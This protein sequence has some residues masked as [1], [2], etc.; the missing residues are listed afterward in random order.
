MEPTLLIGVMLYST[1]ALNSIKENLSIDNVVNIVTKAT[2]PGLPKILSDIDIETA[3]QVDLEFQFKNCDNSVCQT[4]V[5]QSQKANVSKLANM[6]NLVAVKLEELAQTRFAEAEK[7]FEKI[8]DVDPDEDFETA[9]EAMFLQLNSLMDQQDLDDIESMPT[10]VL[11][12]IDAL[13]VEWLGS[14]KRR[15][16]MEQWLTQ[17]TTTIAQLEHQGQKFSAAAAEYQLG[18]IRLEKQKDW[19]RFVLDRGL[20]Y[21]LDLPAQ[22]QSIPTPSLHQVN[23]VAPTLP[24]PQVPEVEDS[25]NTV[26]DKDSIVEFIQA[27]NDAKE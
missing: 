4:T 21:T 10:N 12:K 26:Y 27:W 5:A 16:F 6:Y 1:A 13:A 11:N 15:D 20:G 2:E 8:Q 14:I 24:Q 3:R 22:L 18:G 7:V 23:W 17:H 19:L 9:Q 25:R